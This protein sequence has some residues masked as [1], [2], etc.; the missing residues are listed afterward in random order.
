METLVGGPALDANES[1]G[2]GV[3]AI[4]KLARDR[5]MD[6]AESVKVKVVAIYLCQQCLEEDI[7]VDSYRRSENK[8][9]WVGICQ[10]I[11]FDLGTC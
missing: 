3:H 7:R 2:D 8:R 10:R 4:P 9:W 11:A 5:N 1:Y 6:L